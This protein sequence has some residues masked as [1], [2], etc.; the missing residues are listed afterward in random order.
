MSPVPTDIKL[1][2]KSHIVEITFDDGKH[3]RFTCHKLRESSP[4]ADAK[5]VPIKAD[6]NIVSIEMVGNY[7][8]KFI[9]DDGHQTGIYS[10][11]YLYKLA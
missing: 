10:W 4:A 2:Q 8:V 11:E 3:S 1:L 5:A 9:F 6:V 7:A